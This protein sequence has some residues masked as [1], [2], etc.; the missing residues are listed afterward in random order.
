MRKIFRGMMTATIA[1]GIGYVAPL[2]AQTAGAPIPMPKP[3]LVPTAQDRL[4][5]PIAG[6]APERFTAMDV[7]TTV[8]PQRFEVR[9]PQGAPNV[10][11]ILLD[12]FGFGQSTAYG[13]PI[14]MPT[15][16]RIS[17]SGLRY[18]AFHTTA[19]CSASRAALLTGRNHHVN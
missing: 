12:D 7:R 4:Q 15:L 9:A 8:A 16:E 3:P 1:L 10:V 13:G 5:L 2:S 18:N 19:I 14:R 11:L 6:P 17:Q